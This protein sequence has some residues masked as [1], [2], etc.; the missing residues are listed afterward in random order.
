MTPGSVGILS[1]LE[2]KFSAYISGCCRPPYPRTVLCFYVTGTTNTWVDAMTTSPTTST[3]T[4][5]MSLVL[6]MLDMVGPK[7]NVPWCTNLMIL[8]QTTWRLRGKLLRHYPRKRGPLRP[9]KRYFLVTA[10]VDVFP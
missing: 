1:T 3:I 8:F 4:A 5:M 6:T 9:T 10:W 7:A 2:V